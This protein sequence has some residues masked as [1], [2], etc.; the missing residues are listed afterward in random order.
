[1]FKF[2]VMIISKK[3]LGKLDFVSI[4]SWSDEDAEFEIL[5][6]KNEY[7]QNILCTFNGKNCEMVELSNEDL[8][9]GRI[10]LRGCKSIEGIEKVIKL[11]ND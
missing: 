7:N 10:E 9:N 8:Y 5:N 6:L 11:L 1:M 2:K 4:D 3:Q